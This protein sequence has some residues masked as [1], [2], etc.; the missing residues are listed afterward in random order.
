MLGFKFTRTSSC[1]TCYHQCTQI[2]EI[3][4]FHI[5]LW[6][7]RNISNIC[8]DSYYICGMCAKIVRLFQSR[9]VHLHRTEVIHPHLL[10]VK[11][12]LGPQTR[13][14]CAVKTE[15][16]TT[17][18]NFNEFKSKSNF[19]LPFKSCNCGCARRNCVSA[20]EADMHNM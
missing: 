3:Q 8:V 6:F 15:K 7:L 19:K 12:L 2:C 10:P 9:L 13:N 20:T 11:Q 5:L 17:R 18:M 14:G 1:I 16:Y 4:V